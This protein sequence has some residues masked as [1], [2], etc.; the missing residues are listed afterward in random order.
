MEKK[1]LFGAQLEEKVEKIGLGYFLSFLVPPLFKCL[2][3]QTI[4]LVCS[5]EFVEQP[6]L[7]EL[8]SIRRLN[9]SESNFPQLRASPTASQTRQTY[10]SSYQSTET[11]QDFISISRF[12][13][14]NKNILG[15]VYTP[16]YEEK[17]W[18]P[19]TTCIAA[20]I[21]CVAWKSNKLV[22]RMPDPCQGTW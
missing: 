7:W 9:W 18:L 8:Q 4:L 10:C 11:W 13:N 12:S 21:H 17:N 20:N 3:S 1:K 15:D 14:F 6:F 2:I 16:T 5:V 19:K 22:A